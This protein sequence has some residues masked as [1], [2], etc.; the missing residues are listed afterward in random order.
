MFKTY[1]SWI[2][3]INSIFHDILIYWDTP[4]NI[5]IENDIQEHISLLLS[6]F[7]T[8]IRTTVVSL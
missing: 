8:N 1:L 3:E 5:N 7:Y 2:T 4:V 6:L